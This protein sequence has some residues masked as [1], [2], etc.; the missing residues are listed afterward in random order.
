MSEAELC[1]LHTELLSIRTY[2]IKIGSS[3]RKGDVI[4]RKI[5]EADTLVARFN[6]ILEQIRNLADKFKVED[7]LRIDEKSS[8]F[9]S[10]YDN[11]LDLCS[12]SSQE[13]QEIDTMAKFD[14]KIAMSL[15]PVSSDSE[16]SVKQLIDGIDYYRLD[17]DVESQ[18]K[19]INFVLKNRISQNAKLKLETNYDSVD[20]LIKAMKFHLLP[21]KSA[22]AI[23]AKLNNFKQNNLSLEDYGKEITN[24]FVDLT[25]SQ[26]EGNESNYKVLK[27]INEKHAIKVFSDGLRNRRLSTIIT[28]RNYS[29]LNDAVQ[30]ALDEDSPQP[31]AGNILTM[32]QNN[33]N[34]RYNNYRG[35]W[36]W[37]PRGWRGTGWR[38]GQQ[39]QQNQQNQ[40]NNQGQGMVRG[41]RRGNFQGTSRPRRGYRGRY[42]YNNNYSNGNQQ[43][44]QHMHV[45]TNPEVQQNKNQ[46]SNNADEFFRD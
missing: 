10:L 41:W 33:Y 17:L 30:A 31:Q 2:L 27:K 1:Q 24:M 44:P 15:L 40:N 26:S 19:L 43:K 37:Q 42:Y 28:A 21:K 18:K 45:M 34:N 7:S 3:R 46:S 39:N 12:S 11:I 25:I 20:D 36:N 4:I 38:G 22:P 23:Q 6:V 9:F 29:S 8:Q 13:E 5:K 32:R 16:V 35:R 14:L